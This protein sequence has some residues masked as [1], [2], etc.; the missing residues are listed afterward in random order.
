[1]TLLTTSSAIQGDFAV[2]TFDG[3]LD[4]STARIAEA[5]MT[6][7]LSGPTPHLILDLTALSFMDSNGLAIFI[8]A[9]KTL[10][11]REGT[12]ALAG[13]SHPLQRVTSIAG[14]SNIIPIFPTVQDATSTGPV[15]LHSPDEPAQPQGDPLEDAH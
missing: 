12:I 6:H 5:A 10:R 7:A 11:S 2:I 8:R 14:I 15:A 1:M 9:Y 13:L 3:E 4:Y